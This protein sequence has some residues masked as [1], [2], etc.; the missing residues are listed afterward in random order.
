MITQPSAGRRD[1][2]GPCGEGAPETS[3][4]VSAVTTYPAVGGIPCL[5]LE[6]YH[7]GDNIPPVGGF[8]GSLPTTDMSSPEIFG[9]MQVERKMLR[10]PN[11]PYESP[12]AI[13]H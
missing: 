13:Q 3:S 4:F 6:P 11:Y 1:F 7:P 5:L 2:Q 12:I 10:L 8:G 9:G